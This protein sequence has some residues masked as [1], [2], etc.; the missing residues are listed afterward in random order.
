MLEEVRRRARSVEMS[1]W[2]PPV[3]TGPEMLTHVLARVGHG[4]GGGGGDVHSHL[5]Q[6]VPLLTLRQEHFV[7]IMSDQ[8]VTRIL[9]LYDF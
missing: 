9:S 7:P 5:T 4:G 6:R 2:N 1:R 8:L 3:V